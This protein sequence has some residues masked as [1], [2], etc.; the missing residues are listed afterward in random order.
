MGCEGSK[1]NPSWLSENMKSRNSLNSA[2]SA[3]LA[4]NSSAPGS[5]SLG[6]GCKGL[7]SNST[8]GSS[9]RS[10]DLSHNALA[11][12]TISPTFFDHSVAWSANGMC[13][14][15]VFSHHHLTMPPSTCSWKCTNPL[16]STKHCRLFMERHHKHAS[17]CIWASSTDS[18]PPSGMG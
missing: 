16:S 4:L 9:A 10:E 7:L 15:M 17:N 2:A 12:A 11:F 3:D 14:L 5:F 1:F 18:E 8:N 6:R 13:R